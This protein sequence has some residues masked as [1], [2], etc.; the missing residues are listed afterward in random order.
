MH[1]TH[2]ACLK[3]NRSEFSGNTNSEIRVSKLNYG[4]KMYI[5]KNSLPSKEEARKELL[6]DAQTQII[7]NSL[8]ISVKE[9]VEIVLEYVFNPGKEPQ[10]QVLSDQDAKAHG[11]ETAE[12]IRQWFEKEIT[13]IN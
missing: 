3:R 2:I 8:G 6:G 4:E 9:Y 11:I 7:A 10:M 12:E 1:G 5:S 13:T